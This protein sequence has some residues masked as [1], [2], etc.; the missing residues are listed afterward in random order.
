MLALQQALPASNLLCRLLV[1]RGIYS[2]DAARLFLQPGMEQIRQPE[3]LP[4]IEKARDAIRGAVDKGGL[5]AVY[6]DYDVD[7]VCATAMLGNALEALGGKVLYYL[8]RRQGEGYGLNIAALDALKQ[9]GVELLITVDNGIAALAEAAHARE[10]GLPIIVTDHHEIGETLPDCLALINPRL[11]GSPFSGLCGAGVA[12]K[13]GWALCGWEWAEKWLD[14]AA[15]ATV[16]DMVP[17]MDENRAIVH[18]G[19]HKLRHDAHP[20]LGVLMQ[21]AGVQDTSRCDE[22]TLAFV[23]GPRLNASG[24]MALADT[25]LDLLRARD[26]AG[27]IAPAQALN[28]YNLARREEETAIVA[29]AAAL[30]DKTHT[31][32]DFATV[33]AGEGWNS[34]VVGLVASRLVERYHRPAVV[35]SHGADGRCTGSARSI[36]GVNLY[37]CLH[38]AHGLFERFGGHEMAA[39]MTLCHE[40]VPK[41]KAHMESYLAAHTDASLYQPQAVVD[42]DITPAECTL[43]TYRDLRRLAPFGQGNPAPVFAVRRAKMMGVRTMGA[44]GAHMRLKISDNSGTIDGVGFRM[45]NWA[46]EILPDADYDVVVTLADNTYGGISRCECHLKAIRPSPDGPSALAYIKL[47]LALFRENLWQNLARHDLTLPVCSRM[48]AREAFARLKEGGWG[49]VS[50]SPRGICRQMPFLVESGLIESCFFSF[51]Q[52]TADAARSGALL[53]APGADVQWPAGMKG[54][55]CLDEPLFTA[56][57]MQNIPLYC[58]QDAPQSGG[59]WL[60]G[61]FARARLG[62]LWRALAGAQGMQAIDRMAVIRQIDQV[63]Y[64]GQAL[65][66]A[67]R[68]FEELGLLSFDSAQGGVA[69]HLNSGKKVDLADSRVLQYM[70]FILAQPDTPE[71]MI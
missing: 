70:Q 16:A 4:G 29:E 63:E 12:W 26:I 32:G 61:D 40:N 38:A 53:L 52:P 5:I 1:E 6:G 17:L 68:A 23:L 18:G 39:G 22:Q 55:I 51:E 35:L 49:A 54:V 25:A 37:Q 47:H 50:F 33:V 43:D 67:M 69:L 20:G 21:V 31:P 11:E 46:K 8:P 15:L 65:L 60:K 48:D 14:V 42:T 62:R 56:P 71:D 10:I 3:T 27:A 34:G 59:S 7:G 36:P 58:L 24:R 66:V 13:L 30:V 64:Q 9:Q 57:W 45:G 28:G 19:L 44:D 2:P 41:L